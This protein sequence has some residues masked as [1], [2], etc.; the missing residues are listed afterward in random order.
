V[1]V[2]EGY[3]T[4]QFVAALVASRDKTR[5]YL[6]REAKHGE[7]TTN[8]EMGFK[9]KGKGGQEFGSLVTSWL[10]A[11]PYKEWRNATGRGRSR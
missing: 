10:F 5:K 6:C 9:R 1:G 8:E 2:Y 3:T 4:L 7:V 11:F